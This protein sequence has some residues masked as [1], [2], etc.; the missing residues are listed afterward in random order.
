MALIYDADLN[1]GKLEVARRWLQTQHWFDPEHGEL[2]QVAAYRFDDPADVAGIEMLLLRHGEDL[3]QV[4]VTYRPEPAPAA[5][6]EPI[7]TM[8]HS[9]LGTRYAYPAAADPVFWEQLVHAV[10]TGRGQAEQHDADGS[11]REPTVEVTVLP[12]RGRLPEGA[13]QGQPYVEGTSA[14]LRTDELEAR[15]DR[16]PQ[17]L[18]GSPAGALI[19][20]IGEGPELLLARVDVVS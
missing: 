13:P 1:P 9:V 4:P 7:T 3:L 10:A 6:A 15:I 14:V 5:H 20:R 2:E 17:P 12:P 8:E 16:R 19:G 18:S 11:R